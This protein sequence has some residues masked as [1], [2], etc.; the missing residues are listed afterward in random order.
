LNVSMTMNSMAPP[1]AQSPA[2]PTSGCSPN[3]SGIGS[4]AER[5]FSTRASMPAQ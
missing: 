1:L 3:F 5:R 2:P 4:P